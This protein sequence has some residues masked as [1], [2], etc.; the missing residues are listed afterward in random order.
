MITAEATIAEIDEAI[1]YLYEELKIDKYGNRMNWRKKQTLIEYIDDLLDQRL[2]LTG[3]NREY[4]KIT[5]S[6]AVTRSAERS[7]T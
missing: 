1:G 5:N 2:L 3:G 4:S 7:Q 6:E